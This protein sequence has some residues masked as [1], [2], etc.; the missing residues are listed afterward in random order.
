M[1]LLT[2]I[3]DIDENFYQL[4]LKDREV[5]KLVH[6]DVK[7]MLRTPWNSL[8]LVIQEVGKAVLKNSLLKNTEQFRHLKHYAEGMGIPVDEA[9]YVMLIPELVSSMSKWAP[10]FIKGNL[11]C[12]SFML[13]NPEGE[14]VHGRILDFPLQGSYDRY[15]RAISYDLTGIPKMLGFGASGIPYPSITLMTEDGITLALHQKFTNIF[16]PKG[17]SIFEYIFAL[18]KVAR[19]K[20]SAMEFINS[21]QTI[22]TWC[23]YMTF[24]NGE[25][26]ACDLHG[27]KPFIN[28]LEV[29]ETGILYFCNHLEDKSLNQRQFL[30]LGFDQYNLMRE[31][32]ATKKI[33][34]F[35]N[36]KKTQPTEA[37]LIQ[38]MSTPLD[39]KI[40]SRN[41]KDYELD[42][43]T[44][45]SL[46]IMTMNPS[47][48]RAL[49]LGGPAP[50]I[51][52]TDIIEISDSFGRAKQSPHKLKKAVNFD[53][54]YHTGLHLMMEAQKGFD[55]HDSQA[56]YHYLQMAIDHLE[57]YPERK[58][59][60]FYFLIAQYLYESHPQVLA[61][62]L[63]EFKKFEDHLPPYLNDQCLLFIGRLERILKLPPSLEEDKIQTKKLREIYNRELMIPR[64]VFHVASKGMIVPRIDILDVIYVLTA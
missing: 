18:T 62:L 46:S 25:V 6:Q 28:E 27:D 31:S 61:N 41:F 7:M 3:G 15:E 21:H 12:S 52:N 32:I 34:N 11:G 60:E 42:N 59:A 29:P 1:D 56:I 54:E 4:G 51:F 37:E 47:A 48:G 2:L 22:T 26:L 10:G 33:H 16:N 8:N 30:P 45:T 49:Y 53:P 43:V 40:T 5:G 20:K 57:H 50:K 58:I 24:K 36:K 19:D 23:L 9:A 38:L 14:V 13:R 39:Q 17:M 44:S 35:L 63:G 64:A 55:A